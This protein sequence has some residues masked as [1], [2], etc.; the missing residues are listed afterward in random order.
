MSAVVKTTYEYDRPLTVEA[1]EGLPEGE[2]KQELVDGRVV[3]MAPVG[4]VHGLVA[5]ELHGALR[6]Y[7]RRRRRRP[8][9]GDRPVPVGHVRIETGYQLRPGP[10][11][12]LGT[13]APDVS[14]Y[15]ARPRTRGIVRGAPDLAVEVLSPDEGPAAVGD[16]VAEYLAAG[17]A[18]VW[19]IDTDP[20]HE[21]VTV[22]RPG[23]PVRVLGRED[24]LTGEDVLPGFRLPLA[25]L[26][27][28]VGAEY[29]EDGEGAAD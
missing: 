8:R 12:T 4:D 22:H 14:Y 15:R 2:G 24:V 19:V 26:W 9:G 10:P 5:G 16:K 1:F 20:A 29:E 11:G 25:E 28:T 3:E 21:T 17:V 6:D 27:A 23:R 18:L 13:R 7:V